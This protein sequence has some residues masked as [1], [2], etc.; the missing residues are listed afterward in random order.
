M[1]R[2]SFLKSA[3]LAAVAVPV[4]GLP[5]VPVA[6][7]MP[8]KVTIYTVVSVKRNGHHT[9]ERLVT[10]DRAMAFNEA[11]RLIKAGYFKIDIYAKAY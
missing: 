6:K 10:R 9:T 8:A 4:V 2:R 11:Q 3:A 1:N 7:A 5:A